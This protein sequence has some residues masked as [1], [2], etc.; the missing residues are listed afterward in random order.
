[1][2]N[3]LLTGCILAGG[4]SSRMGTDKAAIPIRGIPA[5]EY[6]AT[7]LLRHC[8]HVIISGIDRPT[9]W[10]ASVLRTTF[11]PDP[12]DQQH[13]GPIV[14]IA[15]AIE[16]TH[17]PLLAVACDMFNLNDAA[18]DALVSAW[19]TAPTTAAG[20]VARYTD[21][22]GS[23]IREPLFAV[24]HPAILPALQQRIA[25]GRRSLRNAILEANF[26][27]WD[28]PMNLQGAIQNFNDPEAL[29]RLHEAP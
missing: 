4:A 2:P 17:M 6:L 23:V 5:L 19:F 13:L 3:S 27:P 20:I 8:D 25:A 11:I 24:Y 15:H 14:G 7:L 26:L 22:S 9:W 21:A 1:M 29:R 28:V 16:L 18:V 10:T 12:P